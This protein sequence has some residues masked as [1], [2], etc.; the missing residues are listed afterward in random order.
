MCEVQDRAPEGSRAGDLLDPEA[1]TEAG[2][3]ESR[4]FSVVSRQFSARVN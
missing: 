3:K 4:Q 1:Q 2:M